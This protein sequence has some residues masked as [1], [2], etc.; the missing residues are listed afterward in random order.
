MSTN[1]YINIFAAVLMA[2]VVVITAVFT[3]F[4]KDEQFIEAFSYSAECS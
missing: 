4:S 3:V 2:V 1:K